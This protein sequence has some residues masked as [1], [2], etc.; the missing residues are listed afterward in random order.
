MISLGIIKVLV[1]LNL[2]RL[3]NLVRK[4]KKIIKLASTKFFMTVKG[5]MKYLL[6]SKMDYF[7]ERKQLS[8]S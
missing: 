2:K 7:R 5:R 4:Y 8:M 1:T 6:I 3:K